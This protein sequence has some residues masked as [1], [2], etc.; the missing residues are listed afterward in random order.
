MNRISDILA[1]KGN[2]AISVL[3]ETSVLDALKVMAENNIGS[4]VVLKDEEFKGIITERD[5][6]RKVILKGKNSTDTKVSDIMT[7]D[8]PHLKP[9]DSVEYCMELLTKN[10]I[11]YLPVFEENKLAG[12]ISISDVVKQTVLVQQETIAHLDNYINS[13]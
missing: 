13:K 3:P 7:T 10:N 4:V 6:S 11:R 5:Y 12:I 2:K 8:L 9:T 1:R